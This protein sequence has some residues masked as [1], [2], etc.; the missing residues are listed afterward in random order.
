M[1]NRR[2]K[3]ESGARA[4]NSAYVLQSAEKMAK[5]LRKIRTQKR[6]VKPKESEIAI[7]LWE[8]G[9]LLGMR[10]IGTL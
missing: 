4:G 7:G 2:S 1:L 10:S 8:N 9:L 3:P 6:I 5:L